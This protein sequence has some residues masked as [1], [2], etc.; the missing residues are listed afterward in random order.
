VGSGSQSIAAKEKSKGTDGR[1][2]EELAHIYARGDA[3]AGAEESGGERAD[4]QMMEVKKI[5]FL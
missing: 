4:G 2:T 3:L 1:L 5:S